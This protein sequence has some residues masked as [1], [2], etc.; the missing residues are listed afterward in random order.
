M[1]QKDKIKSRMKDNYSIENIKKVAEEL[2]LEEAVSMF[3]EGYI[4]LKDEK[5]SFADFKKE[6][7]GRYRTVCTTGM[8]IWNLFYR[9][10]EKD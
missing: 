5:N 1:A 7:N 2:K 6:E 8:S 3:G 9:L 4:R 10:E